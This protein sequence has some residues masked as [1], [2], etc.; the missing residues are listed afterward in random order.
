[1]WAKALRKLDVEAYNY[2]CEPHPFGYPFDRRLTTT[3][4][5]L[6]TLVIRLI[7]FW[8]IYRYFDVF[9]YL[10]ASSITS[11]KP[12]RTIEY[13]L[14]KHSKTKKRL[15][16]FFGD[17]IRLPSIAAK[18]S[19]VWANAYNT[20]DDLNIA[21]M[22]YLSRFFDTVTAGR[23]G[24]ELH[25]YAEPFFKQ[26]LV[27]PVAVDLAEY[28]Y[29]PPT[30]RSPLI[31]HAPSNRAAKGTEHV[32]RVIDKL[33]SSLSFDFRLVTGLPH[34][35]V[36]E[37]MQEADIVVDQL[38]L[39]QYGTLAVEAMSM[40]KP[41]ICYIHPDFVHTYPDTLPIVNATVDTLPDVLTRLIKDPERRRAIGE[42]GRAYVEAVHNSERVAL[43]L[44]DIYKSL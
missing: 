24:G 13:S 7:E 29:C 28:A 31:V 10:Y 11:R 15:M 2:V 4:N 8:R 3:R 17:D 44:L 23:D 14:L 12:L 25:E 34:V 6:H 21:R 43:R 36:I 38:L 32:L 33:G 5:K 26:V 40:G 41:V 16:S 19:S 42:A 22:R 30:N 9:H 1:M 20:K 27:M 35:R 39:G 37:A 18:R